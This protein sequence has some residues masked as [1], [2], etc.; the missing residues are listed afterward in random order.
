MEELLD[1]FST[2][3]E[4]IIQQVQ[5][6]NFQTEIKVLV[7]YIWGEGGTIRPDLGKRPEIVAL[8]F[9]RVQEA[10]FRNGLNDAMLVE[11]VRLDWG[12]NEVAAIQVLDDPAVLGPYADAAI[13]LR[14]AAI[15]W[16]GG[17]GNRLPRRIDIVYGD[18]EL[19]WRNFVARFDAPQ[20]PRRGRAFREGRLTDADV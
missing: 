10:R 16:E 20:T 13:A 7:D 12:M 4:C 9:R 8:W 6:G 14:H 11:S 3:G 18:F 19:R 1:R 2:F 17:P 15:L 5:L